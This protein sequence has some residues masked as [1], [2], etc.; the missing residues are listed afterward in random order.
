MFMIRLNAIPERDAHARATVPTRIVA[1]AYMSM[2][3]EDAALILE[4]LPFQNI[5]TSLRST[6]LRYLQEFLPAPVCT[7][8]KLSKWGF[9]QIHQQLLVNEKMIAFRSNPHFEKS[10]SVQTS[11]F[12]SR[13]KS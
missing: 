5:R 4:V 13:I 12:N 2:Y 6:R 1:R 9:D 11:T 7:D 10:M 3:A 8:M